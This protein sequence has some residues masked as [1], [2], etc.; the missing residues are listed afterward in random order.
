MCF[1]QFAYVSSTAFMSHWHY[2]ENT[3]VE[4]FVYGSHRALF[5]YQ[6][7]PFLS[8][9]YVPFE[10]HFQST[11]LTLWAGLLLQ[12]NVKYLVWLWSSRNYFYCATQRELCG[13]IIVETCLNVS[14]IVALIRHVFLSLVSEISDLFRATNQH[15]VLCEIGKEGKW[16]LCSPLQ[17][18]RGREVM[19]KS[20]FWNTHP[21]HIVRSVHHPSLSFLCHVFCLCPPTC[22]TWRPSIPM[23]SPCT[24]DVLKIFHIM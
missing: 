14:Q 24:H 5:Q 2:W 4:H 20:S 18:V 16:H 8:Y 22:T 23:M 17:G 9:T 6:K 3:G 1:E 21:T 11:L 12:L 13:L 19:K 7:E 10:W 15:S